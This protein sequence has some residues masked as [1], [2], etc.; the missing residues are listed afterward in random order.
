MGLACAQDHPLRGIEI[1]GGLDGNTKRYKYYLSYFTKDHPEVEA[2]A[3]L[4]FYDYCGLVENNFTI[5][6]P[7][8]CMHESTVTSWGGTCFRWQDV[9][10]IITKPVDGSYTNEIRLITGHSYT[11]G[12]RPIDCGAKSFAKQISHY[13]KTK[14]T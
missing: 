4:L 7:T 9:E 6:T 14:K 2:E 5:F 10:Q 12:H 3:P 8:F 13:F 1:F 11:V